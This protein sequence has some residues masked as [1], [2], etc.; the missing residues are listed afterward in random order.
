MTTLLHLMR[1]VVVS[2]EVLAT[3][4]LVC[5]FQ[6][7]FGAFLWIWQAIE[8]MGPLTSLAP[9][10]A[11]IATALPL[12]WKILFPAENSEALCQWAL[13]PRLRITTISGLVLVLAGAA[14]AT[15]G[16]F[17]PA[18]PGRMIGL[19]VSIGYVVAG[20]SVLSMLNA[21]LQVRSLLKGG[22]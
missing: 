6:Y 2:L 8:K 9:F 10:G 5:A 20:L 7:D 3:L 13:Y 21:A 19:L 11:L 17:G 4:L 15:V 1:T 16:V 12:A 18:P 22:R 14:T